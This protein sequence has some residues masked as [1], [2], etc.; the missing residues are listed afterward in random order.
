[1]SGRI[2]YWLTVLQDPVLKFLAGNKVGKTS[3]I[4]DVRIDGRWRRSILLGAFLAGDCGLSG[5]RGHDL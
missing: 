1:V 5:R 2:E 3:A 4:D